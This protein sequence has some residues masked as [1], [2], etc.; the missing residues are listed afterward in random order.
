MKWQKIWVSGPTGLISPPSATASLVLTVLLVV[1]TLSVAA[2]CD[3]PA[4][5]TRSLS[6]SGRSYSG[7]RTSSAVICSKSNEYYL[8]GGRQ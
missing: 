1:P 2:K 4:E 6:C 8:K 5:Q 3:S 7:G